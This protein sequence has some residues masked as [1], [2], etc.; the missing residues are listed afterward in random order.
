MACVECKLLV[1]LDGE[2]HLG[3]EARDARRD[4]YLAEH[5]WI[6]LRFWNTQVFEET[7]AVLE[8]IFRT[9]ELRQKQPVQTL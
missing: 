2:S 3:S 4:A 6:I 9:C 5:G 8:M 7:E 1:E